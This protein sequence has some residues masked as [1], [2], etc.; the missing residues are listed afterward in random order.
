MHC[1]TTQRDGFFNKF[2]RHVGGYKPAENILHPLPL[3]AIAQGQFRNLSGDVR[4]Q[5]HHDTGKHQVKYRPQFGRIGT[6]KVQIKK[7][8]FQA[9]HAC[10]EKTYIE[11]QIKHRK[12]HERNMGYRYFRG[13]TFF[14]IAIIYLNSSHQNR[15]ADLKKNHKQL[16]P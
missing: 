16:N 8:S 14:Q 12:N 9:N 3:G 11:P 15:K 4:Y 1:V 2:L 7:Q 13:D 5:T 10:S 6:G